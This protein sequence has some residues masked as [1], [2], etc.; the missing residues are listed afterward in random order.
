LVVV[1]VTMTPAHAEPAGPAGPAG[2]P[3][4]AEGLA[5]A[6]GAADPAEGQAPAGR[7][8]DPSVARSQRLDRLPFT[9]EHGTRRVVS[10]VG[11][12]LDGMGVGLISDVIA[13]L[14]VHWRITT[15]EGSLIAAAGFAGM[16]IGASLGG[17]PADR[18]GRRSVFALT[19]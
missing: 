1:E 7:V 19:L 15:G 10:G 8:A 16:A 18:I 12:A 4:A 13:A 11:W 3:G 9:R 14:S 17:L 5:P 2:P 6:G